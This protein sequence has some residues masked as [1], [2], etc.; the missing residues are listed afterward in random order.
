MSPLWPPL[1]EACRKAGVKDA[2]FD[3]LAEHPYSEK[4]PE[5][6][7]L[8]GGIHVLQ[9]KFSEILERYGISSEAVNSVMI[10]VRFTGLMLS[11]DPFRIVETTITSRDGK[12]FNS[13]A[14]DADV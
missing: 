7:Q 2:Q 3:L 4:L 8:R 14:G 12:S 9:H 13:V 5:T 1:Y 11:V 10:R 6:G